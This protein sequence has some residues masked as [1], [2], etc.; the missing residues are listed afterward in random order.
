MGQ[1]PKSGQKRSL[2]KKSTGTGKGTGENG[3]T[4][5]GDASVA[6]SGREQNIVKREEKRKHHDRGKEEKEER[7]SFNGDR[8]TYTIPP[9]LKQ[10]P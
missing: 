2:N 10:G 9:M 5:A 4:I 3:K 8:R 6:G 7:Q 1:L